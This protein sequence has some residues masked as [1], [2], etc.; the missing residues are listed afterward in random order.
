M[1]VSLTTHLQSAASARCLS[2]N[3]LSRN[4]WTPR[5]VR[6]GV[7]TC[8]CAKKYKWGKRNSFVCSSLRAH[9]FL[10][11]SSM[12]WLPYLL[13]ERKV[14]CNP[15]ESKNELVIQP[16][17]QQQTLW[18]VQTDVVY[19]CVSLVLLFLNI[20]K[21]EAVT[22][23]TMSGK[24]Y[25]L[26]LNITFDSQWLCSSTKGGPVIIVGITHT[27]ILIFWFS[28]NPLAKKLEITCQIQHVHA[29]VLLKHA[30]KFSF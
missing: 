19:V 22:T 7:H 14:W 11:T 13:L 24:I 10:H 17:L 16:A 29:R 20:I 1:C 30:W 8:V 6:M 9:L 21:W 25:W 4:R 28:T 3:K 27:N 15:R 26:S 12:S 18:V 5:A 23:N 2:W